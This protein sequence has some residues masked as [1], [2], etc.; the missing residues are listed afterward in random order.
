ML[1]LI[2][3][4]NKEDY[5]CAYNILSKIKNTGRSLSDK[6]DRFNLQ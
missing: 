3:V 2:F 4:K 6:V 5:Q 1:S